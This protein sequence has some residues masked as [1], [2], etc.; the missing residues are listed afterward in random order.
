MEEKQELSSTDEKMTSMEVENIHEDSNAEPTA[1]PVAEIAPDLIA[2]EHN[3]VDEQLIVQHDDVEA[4]IAEAQ[5]EDYS[6]LN[7]TE[8]IKKLETVLT[9]DDVE[10]VKKNVKDIKT[11]YQLQ[12]KEEYDSKLKAFFESGGKK[13]EF[14]L[15][16]DNDD[17]QFETL[18]LLFNHKRAEQR[19][20]MEKQMNDNLEQKKV[21]IEELKT[22]LESGGNISLS[23]KK[24]HD[25]QNKWRAIG[26]VPQQFMEDLWRSYQFY[27]TK[28]YDLI[29]I[30]HDLRDMDFKKNLELKT[31]LCEKAEDLLLEPSIRK[32]LQEVRVLQEKWRSIGPVK[33]E[34]KDI[35]WERFKSVCD[36]IYEKAKEFLTE[37]DEEFKKNLDAK[38]ALCEQAELIANASYTRVNHWQTATDEIEKLLED[39]KK[40]GFAAKE[41]GEAIWKRFNEARN[42]FFD[43]K[44]TFF[45]SLKQSLNHN[46]QLKTDIINEVTSLKT[47]TDWKN[48]TEIIQKLQEQ[49]KS[50]G[51]APKNVNDKLWEKFRAECNEFFDNKKNHFGAKDEQEAANLKLK[52]ELVSRIEQYQLSHDN[53]ENMNALKEFQNEWMSIEFVPM[54]AKERINRAYRDAIDKK[55]EGIIG[56]T[57]E[58]SRGYN[59]S[60]GYDRNGGPQSNG[61]GDR[62]EDSRS[63]GAQDKIRDLEKEVSVWENNIGFFGKSKGAEKLKEEMME[64]IS[65]AKEQIAELKKQSKSA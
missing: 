53:A 64:K 46:T 58:R 2:E 47:S 8:L 3:L 57:N 45:K 12:L 26:Y 32:S 5:Q 31:E 22:L 42:K 20:N 59:S 61:F 10:S 6:V 30:N 27:I 54:K 1:A 60:Q 37:K 36:K 65:K 43:D 55:F 41:K 62:R 56:S 34:Y 21:I 44:T 49:W 23:L 17:Q 33:L 39:W 63:S 38:T 16:K 25:L 40:V 4:K 13:E 14:S 9:T 48:T 18:I 7:K 19:K 15:A 35:I 28:F 50:I 29:K 51:P 24:L 11:A 52:E